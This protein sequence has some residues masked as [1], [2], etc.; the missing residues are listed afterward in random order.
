[1][2]SHRPVQ[3]SD[4]A[5]LCDFAQTPEELFFFYPKADYPLTV[6]QLSLSVDQRSHSTI[7]EKDGV[8]AGFANFYQWQQGGCCKIGNVIV[9]PALRQQGIATYLITTMIKQARDCF[10]ANEVQV[11]CFSKNTAALLFY[12]KLGFVPFDVEERI[13]KKGQRVAL[14]HLSYSL[15]Y[16]L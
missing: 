11:A 13:N 12:K 15:T 1:M 2:L 7:V 5:A 6:E 4:L 14:I 8:S 10:Q 9:N 16:I 3:P